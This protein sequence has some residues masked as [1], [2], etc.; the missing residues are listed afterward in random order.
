[1]NRRRWFRTVGGGSLR[2]SR[3]L[4]PAALTDD[5]AVKIGASRLP[6][7]AHLTNSELSRNN[8]YSV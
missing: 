3:V 6:K 8:R 2:V 1:M 4:V 5:E 7:P